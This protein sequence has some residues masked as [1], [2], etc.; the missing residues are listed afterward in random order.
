MSEH[1]SL[2]V[3]EARASLSRVIEPGDLLGC[4]MV[5]LLGPQTAWELIRAES[6]PPTSSQQGVAEA[7]ERAYLSQRQRSLRHGLARWRTRVRQADGPR[8]LRR[9]RQLGGDLLI[10]ED[11]AWPRQLDELHPA[12]PLGLWFRTAPA[13]ASPQHTMEELSIRMPA[14]HRRVAVVGA[15]EMTDYGARVAYELSEELASHGVTIISGGAYGI[16]AAAHRGALAAARAAEH[17]SAP[18][19]AVLA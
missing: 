12:A 2:S 13:G 7:A 15:R 9:I 8:D 10:P 4:L 1:L 11:A 14:P 16:D 17:R 3:R 6:A 5:S 19:L 18:T